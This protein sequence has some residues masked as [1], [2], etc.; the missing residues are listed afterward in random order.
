MYLLFNLNS[1]LLVRPTLGIDAIILRLE[2][3]IT[4]FLDFIIDFIN[5][6]FLDFK[7]V[8]VTKRSGKAYLDIIFNLGSIKDIIYKE[9][10][11]KLNN[12]TKGINSSLKNKNKI[13]VLL[14]LIKGVN[15]LGTKGLLPKKPAS[16]DIL[17]LSK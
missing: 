7:A 9:F 4:T 12:L 17:S 10:N 14:P 1:L 5:L 8:K 16:L 3:F 15:N 13:R 11:P 6:D 2:D